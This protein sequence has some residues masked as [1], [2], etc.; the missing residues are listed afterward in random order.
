[1]PHDEYEEDGENKI[2]IYG[3]LAYELSF[4][5]LDGW[6]DFEFTKKKLKANIYAFFFW[7][8]GI[9]GAIQYLITEK[10]ILLN[11][12]YFDID[13]WVTFFSTNENSIYIIYFA[14]L[15]ALL[16]SGIGY[17]LGLRCGVKDARNLSPEPP[18]VTMENV[19]LY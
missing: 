17:F 4:L 7:F 10:I 13:L 11:G 12:D 1:M 14:L 16:I 3:R 15:F 19:L 8:L 6:K 2:R 9:S 18:M 5:P